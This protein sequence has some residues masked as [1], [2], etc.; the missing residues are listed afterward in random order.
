MSGT[1][2]RRAVVVGAGVGGLATAA[3]LAAAGVSVTV[4][5]QADT[6]GGKLGLREVDGFRFDTG[7]SLVTLPWT[8]A[9]TLEATG[10]DVEDVLELQRLDPIARYRFGDGTWLDADAEEARFV[11]RLEEEV[12]PGAGVQWTALMDRASAMWDASADRVLQQPLDGVTDLL[13][14]AADP[15]DIATTA[16]HRSLRSLGREHLSDPRLRQ[17]LDRYATY[18]GS[19][20]RKAPAVLATVAWA[21]R[22]WGGWYVTGGLRRIG[23]VLAD[24]VRACGGQIRTSTRVTEVRVAAGPSGDRVSG[25]SVEGGEVLD[26]DVVVLNADAGQV[27]QQLLPERLTSGLRR[28]LRVAPRSLGGW[29]ML[30]GIAEDDAGQAHERLAHHTVLFAERYDEEFDA[31]FG[32]QPRYPDRPTVYVAVADDPAVAPAGHRAVFVLVNAPRTDQVAGP[33]LG[34]GDAILGLMARRGVDLRDRIVL[35]EER[36]PADLQR[37]TLTPGGAIYGTS[38]N[39]PLAAFLRPPNNGPA[40]GL[41]L[42][43]GSAHP[44]GGLPLVL[45]SARIVADAVLHSA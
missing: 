39:G 33:P 28:R 18:S 6:V 29:V 37:D 44:G 38:S 11:R 45:M 1:V 5:E 19:D 12:H 43:G 26:A 30:L 41:Y 13:R 3:R 2:P 10:V 15:R 36:T 35:R 21:E 32:R 25:V 4:L 23:E 31:L 14:L 24:R 9:A 27:V 17:L 7:P 40:E 16:P 20:P 8:L 42:V 22:R 34:Y